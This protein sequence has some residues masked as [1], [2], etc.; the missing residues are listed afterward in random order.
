MTNLL[1]PYGM[2][3]EMREDRRA[4]E[5]LQQDMIMKSTVQHDKVD[6]GMLPGGNPLVTSNSFSSLN[7]DD[8]IARTI[9]M[10]VN[11]DVSNFDSINMLKDLESAR[12]ALH[13]KQ[14]ENLAGKNYEVQDPS[15]IQKDSETEGKLLEWLESDHSDESDFILVT[16]KKRTRKPVQRLILSGKKKK[17]GMTR[18]IL[19]KRNKGRGTSWEAQLPPSPQYKKVR[20]KQNERPDMEL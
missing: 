18:K 19:V 14:Q 4:S 3:R 10:G 12:L 17:T 9:S 5:R 6:K 16:S 1:N 7:D 15:S 2:M 13:L 8:I 11:I 20:K